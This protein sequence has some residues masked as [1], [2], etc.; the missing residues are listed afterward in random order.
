M[1]PIILCVSEL[2]FFQTGEQFGYSMDTADLNQDGY[3][4]WALVPTCGS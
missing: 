3:A 1:S 4:V 2:L